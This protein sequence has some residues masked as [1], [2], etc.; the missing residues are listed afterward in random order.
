MAE[1]QISRFWVTPDHR[2]DICLGDKGIISG[3]TLSS[4]TLLTPR[5]WTEV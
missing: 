5:N 1:S 4:L 2:A 3:D